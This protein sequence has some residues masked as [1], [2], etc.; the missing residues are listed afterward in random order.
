MGSSMGTQSSNGD[1]VYEPGNPQRRTP[2]TAAELASIQRNDEA[3]LCY[4][5]DLSTKARAAVF[6]TEELELSIYDLICVAYAALSSAEGG[7]DVLV[8][9]QGSAASGRCDIEA[10]YFWSV[11][12]GGL[13][14]ARLTLWAMLETPT[15]P[16]LWKTAAPWGHNAI[17]KAA[18]SAGSLEQRLVDLQRLKAGN[19]I[20]NEE[21][22]KLRCRI[23]DSI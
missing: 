5:L 9:Q 16:G 4:G 15:D 10:L 12:S 20:T 19:L 13:T 21:Y 17:S 23:I 22:R 8:K 7:L 18:D 2:A 6:Y 14:G 1:Q 11:A 3:R